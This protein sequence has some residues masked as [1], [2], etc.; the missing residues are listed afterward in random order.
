MKTTHSFIPLLDINE[1]LPFVIKKKKDLQD[2]FKEQ[3]LAKKELEKFISKLEKAF[4]EDISY[5]GLD[6]IGEKS[7]E[8]FMF[9][10]SGFMEVMVEA[11]VALNAHFPNKR[12]AKKFCDALK[13]AL[14]GSLK[15]SPGRDMLV[16]S[17]EVQD[18][19]DT[20]LTVEGWNKIKGI[21]N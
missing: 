3:D 20:S 18:E 17:I 11:P 13:V 4:K 8:R 1:Q 16:D 5:I 21:R 6:V 15:K 2:T 12:R 19:N 10:G 14:K 9:K 7:Y